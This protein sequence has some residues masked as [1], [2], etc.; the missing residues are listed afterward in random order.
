[1]NEEYFSFVGSF[2]LRFAVIV[3][4]WSFLLLDS[5]SVCILLRV[6]LVLGKSGFEENCVFFPCSKCHT[7]NFI[8][9]VL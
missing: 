3:G 9:L 2:G 6:L 8:L 4:R 7:T 1:V 5:N